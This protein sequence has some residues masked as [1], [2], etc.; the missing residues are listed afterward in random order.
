[1]DKQE[2]FELRGHATANYFGEECYDGIELKCVR[3]YQRE[4]YWAHSIVMCQRIIL[5]KYPRL[6]TNRKHRAKARQT[7]KIIFLYWRLGW[8]ASEIARSLG[9]KLAAVEKHIKRI[10]ELARKL[11]MHNNITDSS[12]ESFF[13]P[14]PPAP[15]RGRVLVESFKVVTSHPRDLR[16]LVTLSDV[17]IRE[18]ALKA[19]SEVEAQNKEIQDVYEDFSLL[20]AA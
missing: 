14:E 17:A 10:A 6:A 20:E 4:E 18:Q 3:N 7:A 16:W 12:G 9:L 19:L 11:I 15:R 2:R 5:K 13:A 8:S 1:M